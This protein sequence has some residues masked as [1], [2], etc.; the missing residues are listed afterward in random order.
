MTKPNIEFNRYHHSVYFPEDYASMVLEFVN[1][2]KGDVDLTSHAAEQMYDKN[3][4]RGPIPLPTNEELLEY[5]NKLVE[6]YERQDRTGRIQKALIR[7]GGLSEKY[8][9]SYI[10]ARDGV[11]ITAWANDKEDTHRLTQS[12]KEYVQPPM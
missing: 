12:L 2:F 10:V 8:D 6:F 7:V 3:D 9:Y 1:S 4:H 11:I 5:S